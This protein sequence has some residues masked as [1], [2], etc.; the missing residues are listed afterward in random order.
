MP[1]SF[2]AATAASADQ[3]GARVAELEAALAAA[4]GEVAE[5]KRAA[6]ERVAIAMSS[7]VMAEQGKSEVEHALADRLE[8]ARQEALAAARL[9]QEA[10]VGAVAECISKVLMQNLQMCKS[11]QMMM[12]G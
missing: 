10:A 5:A 12:A 11:I 7:A 4:R 9:E 3:E 2:A 6:D 8:A 1:P